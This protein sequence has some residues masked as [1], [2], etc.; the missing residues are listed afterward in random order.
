MWGLGFRTDFVKE[1]DAQA[2]DV[3]ITEPYTNTLN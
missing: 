3:L 1:V 2:H